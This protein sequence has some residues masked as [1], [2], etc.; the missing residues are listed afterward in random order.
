MLSTSFFFKKKI[1]FTGIEILCPLINGRVPSWATF[2]FSSFPEEKLISRW[3]L[4]IKSINVFGFNHTRLSDPAEL[5]LLV[6]LHYCVGTT[7]AL[8]YEHKT[9]TDKFKLIFF[10]FFMEVD[11]FIEYLSSNYDMYA[12]SPEDCMRVWK[13]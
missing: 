9:F 1:H 12:C 7:S 3:W 2:L 6:I 13:S 8:S 10:I 5:N 11:V 4:V